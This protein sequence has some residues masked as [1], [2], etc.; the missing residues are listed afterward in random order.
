M[1]SASL[2][3][4]TYNI[5]DAVGADHRFAPERIA[6]VLAEIGADLFALQEVGASRDGVDTLALLRDATGFHAVPGSAHCDRTGACGNC[7]LSR[8]PVT[9]CTRLDLT[10]AHRQPR[11]ALD[12]VIDCAGSPLRVLAT[13]LGLRPAERR[14]QVRNLLNTLEAETPHPTLLMGDLN[15]WFLW[16]RPLRWLHAHFRATPSPPSFPARAPLLAL[17]RIWVEPRVLLRRLWVHSGP[18]ARA[19]S[20]HLP[21]VAQIELP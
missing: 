4:A 3:V 1:T 16:G 13:H 18:A 8:H 5:H 20:D 6:A 11:G 15:E 7:L 9:E 17:D 2:I 14:A 10:V 21:V 19:A 12:A